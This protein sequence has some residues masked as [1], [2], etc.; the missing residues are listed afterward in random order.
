MSGMSNELIAGI[1]VC[2]EPSHSLIVAGFAYE[3]PARDAFHALGPEGLP[4]DEAL[5]LLAKSHEGFRWELLRLV[6]EM[7]EGVEQFVGPCI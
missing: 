5:N 1:F 6:H 7:D 3:D 4:Q 2:F